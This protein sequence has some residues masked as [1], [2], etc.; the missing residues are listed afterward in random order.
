MNMALPAPVVWVTAQAFGWKARAAMQDKAKS[1]MCCV[2]VMTISPEY[3]RV[4][5]NAGDWP[6][7]VVD[8][9]E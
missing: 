5:L 1:A 4:R 3:L 2:R 7:G 6:D 9:K 8:G